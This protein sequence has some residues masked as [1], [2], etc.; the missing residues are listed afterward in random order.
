MIFVLKLLHQIFLNFGNLHVLH[1]YL[2]LPSVSKFSELSNASHIPGG[3]KKME[4]SI[5]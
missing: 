5:F 1:V 4:Q 2:F 3:P